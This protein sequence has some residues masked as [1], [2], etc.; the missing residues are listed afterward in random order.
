MDRAERM[1]QEV[2]EL[3]YKGY[4][5]SNEISKEQQRLLGDLK[6]TTRVILASR[7]KGGIRYSTVDF[8]GESLRRSYHVSSFEKFRKDISIELETEFL[9]KNP[10]PERGLRKAFT[11][12]MHSHK[13]HWSKCCRF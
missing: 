12:F 9:N 6:I 7:L 11:C 2:L 5:R 4:V 1:R 8:F 3:L 13:L 10:S